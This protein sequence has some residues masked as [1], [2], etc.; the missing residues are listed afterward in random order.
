MG[1]IGEGVNI[2]QPLKI[3]SKHFLALKHHFGYLH[4]IFL[5]SSLVIQLLEALIQ[6]RDE[7]IVEQPFQVQVKLQ[8]QKQPSTESY[9]IAKFSSLHNSDKQ[10]SVQKLMSCRRVTCVHAE[11]CVC[12][13]KPW[14]NMYIT[15]K[16]ACKVNDVTLFQEIFHAIT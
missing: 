2:H 8:D 14:E 1:Y 10:A 11:I 16:F 12:K 6:A 13:K 7:N 3:S 4:Q 5:I 15:M 9:E